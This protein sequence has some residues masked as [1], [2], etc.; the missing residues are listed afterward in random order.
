MEAWKRSPY[1]IFCVQF[2]PGCLRKVLQC[3][4]YRGEVGS[5][6]QDAAMWAVPVQHLHQIIHLFQLFACRKSGLLQL[7]GIQSQN[8]EALIAEIPSQHE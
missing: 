1:R 5:F 2:M 6:A 7:F 4:F 3:G 8:F